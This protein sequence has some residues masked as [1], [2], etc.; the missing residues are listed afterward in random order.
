M[1]SLPSIIGYIG[2]VFIV[3]SFQFD[4]R[5]KILGLHIISAVFY[6]IHFVL[7]GALTGAAMAGLV[8]LRNSIFIKRNTSRW[9]Q[10]NH[11][12]YIFI[13]IFIV[14]GAL[15]W[16]GPLSILPVIGMITGT[17]SRWSKKEKM[18]RL[19]SLIP[20][21]FWLVYNFAVGSIPA[22]MGESLVLGS[23][24]TS[25][26]RFDILKKKKRSHK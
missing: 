5:K 24:I 18:L 3:L 19:L 13:V 15:T 8:V 22:F 9:A 20:S 2:L 14:A 12:P 16:S 21:P 26:I 23:N 10:R 17:I 11:W 6:L 4:N 25:I 1:L 7:I